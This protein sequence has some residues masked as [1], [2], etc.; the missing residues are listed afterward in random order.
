MWISIAPLTYEYY[1]QMSFRIIDY[2]LI[3]VI[4]LINQPEMLTV[5]ENL[6]EQL[7]QQRSVEEKPIKV[8]FSQYKE[9]IKKLVHPSFMD[10]YFKLEQPTLIVK[11]EKKS[12]IYYKLTMNE[13]KVFNKTWKRS[14]RFEKESNVQLKDLIF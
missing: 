3:Q 1:Q 4:L 11:S 9:V 6:M 8:L 10:M 5:N 13:L 2:L 7:K 12:R 14:K